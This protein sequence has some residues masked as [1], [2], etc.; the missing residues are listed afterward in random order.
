MDILQ[1]IIQSWKIN[2]PIL[3]FDN[4]KRE[5]EV[6]IMIPSEFVTPE[7]VNLMR[8]EAGGLICTALS[9]EVCEDIQLPFMHQLYTGITDKYP[10][11]KGMLGHG[12]PYGARSSFSVNV[13]HINAFTG[14][15]D[16]DRALTISELGRFS[17]LHNREIDIF[18][19]KFRLPGHVPILRGAD[20]LLKNRL[21]HTELGLALCELGGFSPSITMCE[22]MG[23][24]G[25]ALSINDAKDFADKNNLI[26]ID[27][28]A[29]ID[30]WCDVKNIDH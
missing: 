20:G 17:S 9:H 28:Q 30:L 13:N 26:Y 24:N 15:T 29:V 8:K 12:L 2:K 14:I 11:I 18:S 27:G 6:D 3:L 21:G 16:D 1:K 23:D 5:G 7:I 10:V 25:G 19:K 22:M 4:P